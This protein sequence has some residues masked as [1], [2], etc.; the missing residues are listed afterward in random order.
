[1]NQRKLAKIVRKISGL[2][3][4]SQKSRV[5]QRVA[6]SLGRKRASHGSYSFESVPFPRLPPVSIPHHSKDV[7]RFTADNILSHLEQFD[8]PAWEEALRSG[9]MQ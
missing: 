1:M 5:L 2:Y 8:V 9:G 6:E 3:G 7:N 4:S